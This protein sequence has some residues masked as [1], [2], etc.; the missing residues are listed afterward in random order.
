MSAPEYATD[1]HLQTVTAEEF[2]AVEE[3]GADALLGDRDDALIA[4]GSD[5]MIFGAGGTGKTTLAIDLA[6]HLAAGSESW[7]GIPVA[8]PVRV[9][10]IEN[11]GPRAL[12]RAKF[13]RKL[14]AWMIPAL[15]GRLTIFER[16]WG[17]FTFTDGDWTDALAEKVAEDEIDVLIAGP[18]TRL[19]MDDAGT[20]QEV[21]DF[22][23]LVAGVR[24]K[25]GRALAVILLHHENKGGAVSGAWEGSGDTLL[26]V[27]GRGAGQTHLHVQKARWS[28]EHHAKSLDLAWTD[29]EGF[30][31]EDEVVRDYVGEVEELLAR[32]EWPTAKEIAA[33]PDKGGIGASVDTIKTAL[34]HRP[35]V[36]I[37]RTGEAA[38][39]VGRHRNAI[40]YGLLTST[41][42]SDESDGVPG[43]RGVSD[44]TPPYTPVGGG[45]GSQTSPPQQT[46]LTSPPEP[47]TLTAA[48]GNGDGGRPLVERAIR[49]AGQS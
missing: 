43:D 2:A 34:K 5:V 29:G 37:E 44:S 17:E 18:V 28:S 24:G 33:P 46:E 7:L 3:P 30:R 48:V 1:Y 8:R 27:E 21:R 26:H 20:L 11:E 45:G 40:V 19:G 15:K 10:I 12:L 49:E 35:D 25:S 36:F 13:R 38:V 22:M 23:Q 39:E 6:F 14:A 31:V 16:P 47:D 41:Q 4:V 9:L 42:K 32:T